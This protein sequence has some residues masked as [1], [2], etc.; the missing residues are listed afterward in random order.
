LAR[1]EHVRS[2]AVVDLSL[3]S[4]TL[5]DDDASWVKK[6]D[7]FARYVGDESEDDDEMASAGASALDRIAKAMGGKVVWPIFKECIKPY[8][9]ADRWQLRRAAVIGT[10]LIVEGCKKVL[11]PQVRQLVT[12]IAH[13]VV[14]P[15]LRV[16]HAA[17]RTL[18]QIILDFTDPDAIETIGGT[19]LDPYGAVSGKE[20]VH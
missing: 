12:D 8:A 3:Y 11:L 1:L 16:R 20:G 18:G 4:L 15:H 13:F 9:A 14:D 2:Q 5:V 10:S 6:A 19:G 17:L 7:D